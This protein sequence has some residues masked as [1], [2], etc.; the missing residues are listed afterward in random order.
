[1]A[2]WSRIKECGLRDISVTERKTYNL[3]LESSRHPKLREA[4]MGPSLGACVVGGGAVIFLLAGLWLALSSFRDLL[5]EHSSKQQL[6][7]NS[8]QGRFGARHL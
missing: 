2:G 5:M 7:I 3:E 4:D 8:G 1:M 6:A